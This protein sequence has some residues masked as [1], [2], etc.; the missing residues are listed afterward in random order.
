MVLSIEEAI[1]SLNYMKNRNQ[2]LRG[3]VEALKSKNVD[4]STSIKDYEKFTTIIGKAK[5][6][7]KKAVDIIYENSVGDLKNV[8]NTALKYIFYDKNYEVDVLIEDKRGTK[9]LSFLLLDLDTGL[10]VDIKDGIGNGVR[11]VMS[12]VIHTFYLVNKDSR[13]LILD[14]AYSNL[15]ASYVDRFFE[16]AKKLC[17]KKDLCI[18]LISHDERF[19]PL[20]DK[21]YS[22]SDG[23]V[24]E[25]QNWE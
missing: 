11:V 17:E 5:D 20:L 19:I 21:V 10:E 8:L 1:S 15:S 24:T 3:T 4:I 13:I 9:T 22:V 18:I 6:F 23:H 2:Q 14:E 16:F 12:F 7:Y 25:V